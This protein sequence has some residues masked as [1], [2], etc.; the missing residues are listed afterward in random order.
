[1]AW[2]GRQARAGPADPVRIPFVV[3][4]LRVPQRL[5]VHPGV[6]AAKLSCS[7]GHAAPEL[8]YVR[9]GPRNPCPA[10]RSALFFAS[11]VGRN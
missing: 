1:M 3:C 2:A 9:P 7:S 6:V 8:L 10:P 4:I 11:D 5:T